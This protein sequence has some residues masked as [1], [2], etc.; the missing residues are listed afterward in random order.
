MATQMYIAG[1]ELKVANAHRIIQEIGEV[2]KIEKDNNDGKVY[3][4]NR[5]AWAWVKF[6]LEKLSQECENLLK[7]LK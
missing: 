4:A 2:R 7:E 6:Q 1:Q 3:D 5:E